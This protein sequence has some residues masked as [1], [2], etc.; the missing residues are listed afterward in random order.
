M[1][2]NN[3][4]ADDLYKSYLEEMQSL[5]NFR[6]SYTSLHAQA[7]I[8]RED[9]EVRRLLDA[10]AFF[11]ARTRTS[12]LRNLLATQ[13][14]LFQQYFSFLASPLPATAMVQ[15]VVS[16]KL[17]EVVTLPRNAEITLTPEGRTGATLRTMSEL[18]ILPI[19]LEDV[20]TLLRSRSGLRIVLTF[21]AAHARHDD[22]GTLPLHVNHLDDY[23][24]SLGVLAN[25]KKHLESA[26]VVYDKEQVDDETPG[27]PCEVTY[28][29]Q[30]APDEVADLSHPVQLVRSFF[31]FP[32][33]E[34]SLNVKVAPAHG[35]WTRFSICLDV[36]ADWPRNL[37]LNKDMFQLFTVPVWNLKRSH[38]QPVLCDGTGKRFPIRYPTPQE[39][40]QLHSVVGVYEI[41][42]KGLQPLKPG[43]VTG[44]NGSFEIERTVEESG[45]VHWL[46]LEFPE[47]FTAPKKIAIDAFWY[48]PS[49][50]KDAGAKLKVGLYGRSILGAAFELRGEVR[51]HSE[52]PLG[53]DFEGMLQLLALKSKSVGYT[54]DDLAVLLSALGSLGQSP[55]RNLAAAIVEASVS[56]TPGSREKGGGQDHFY[57]MR[58]REPDA[59]QIPVLET[60]IRQLGALLQA[61]TT[62]ARVRIEA[63]FED[64][65]TV[66]NVP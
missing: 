55:F 11:T 47:A 37:R 53:E 58:L 43:I 10:M 2:G 61:W 57:K 66:V 44:G 22:V 56:R 32:Q 33:R 39:K 46:K 26:S 36:D 8:D 51:P 18:R 60:G 42:E 4:V 19:R 52:N 50:S 48:Q 20:T 41:K 31:H 34:L 3:K 40:F 7:S 54:R 23:P 45:E 14:R 21:R 16:G 59:T 28:G 63:T 35:G 49:F 13:R 5:E 1:A 9:P 12:A 6:V 27:E 38:A 65:D 29:A 24:A 64:A 25:L 62:D 15:A 17:A 30:A